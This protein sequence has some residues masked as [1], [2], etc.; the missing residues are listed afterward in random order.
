MAIST[1]GATASVS[2][3]PASRAYIPPTNRPRENSIYIL[4][5]QLAGSL[6][7][8]RTSA[9]NL[10]KQSTS[11]NSSKG[12]RTPG[13]SQNS[14]VPIDETS[15]FYVG[16]EFVPLSSAIATRLASLPPGG[17]PKAE[18]DLEKG[19]A[20]QHG[21]FCSHGS[22]EVHIGARHRGLS[23]PVSILDLELLNKKSVTDDNGSVHSFKSDTDHGSTP[24]PTAQEWTA[25]IDRVSDIFG[26]M[27]ADGDRGGMHL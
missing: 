11:A 2:A 1:I 8:Q 17:F 4:P 12:N 14:F 21:R 3:A 24:K 22:H 9:K 27:V 20:S 5:S 7:T 25:D 18:F 15:T 16:P 19:G 23:A 13:A 26:S 10:P 6:E